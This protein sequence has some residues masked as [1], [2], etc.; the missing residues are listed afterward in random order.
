MF[1]LMNG[2]GLQARSFA[3]QPWGRSMHFYGERMEE[4]I[5]KAPK[6]ASP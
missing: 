3:K 4:K 5:A 6:V 1:A 2:K